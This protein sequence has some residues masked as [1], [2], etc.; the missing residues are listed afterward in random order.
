[1]KERIAV[2]QNK[3]Q[4]LMRQ[5]NSSKRQVSQM[6]DTVLG[7]QG[8]ISMLQELEKEPLEIKCKGQCGAVPGVCICA[9][10][11]KNARGMAIRNVKN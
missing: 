1:M 9:E 3:L 7:L 10:N 4:M 11:I 5:I 8:R 6:E 2:E